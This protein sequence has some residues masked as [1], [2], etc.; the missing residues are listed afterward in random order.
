MRWVSQPPHTSRSREVGPPSPPARWR[1]ASRSGSRSSCV[2]QIRPEDEASPLPS[3]H[4]EECRVL[5]RRTGTSIGALIGLL[6]LAAFAGRSVQ[7]TH[8]LLSASSQLDTQAAEFRCLEQR[9]EQKVP[10]SSSV[11]FVRDLRNDPSGLWHQRAIEGSY[12]RYRVLTDRRR[13][14]YV[15]TVGSHGGGCAGLVVRVRIGP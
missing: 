9:I 3:P 13:S 6:V 11:F 2:L 15:V 8:S 7:L 10:K 5:N 4:G 12:P 1:A 14:D